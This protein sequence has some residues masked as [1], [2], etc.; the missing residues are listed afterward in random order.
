MTETTLDLVRAALRTDPTVTPRDRTRLLRL[1]RAG[2]PP[3]PQATPTIAERIVRR[4]EAAQ[5]IGGSLRLVDRLAK[6]GQLPRV[7]L[8]GRK[9]GA[10]FRLS[11]ITR[12]ISSSPQAEAA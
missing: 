4:D 2:E 5:L 10:G 6:N 8:P 3:Q 11:D 7:T 1:L 12:L 9:R